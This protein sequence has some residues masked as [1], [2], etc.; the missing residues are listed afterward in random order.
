[1]EPLTALLWIAAISS[2]TAGGP[3]FD[4]DPRID[5]P[6][7]AAAGAIAFGWSLSD[8]LGGPRCAP[9]CRIEDVAVLDRWV[10]GQYD[11]TWRTVSDISSA[12]VLLGSAAVLF[13]DEAPLDALQDAV[14]VAQSV[15][16]ANAIGVAIELAAR[17]PRPL[18]YSARVPAEERFSG[19]SALSFPS[20]HTAGAFAATLAMYSA[21]ERLHPD[22]AIP[23]VVLGVGLGAASFLGV[24]RV[25]AGDHFP[26][27]VIM[28]AVI[29]AAA[30]LV[31]PALHDAPV[32]LTGGAGL[33]S[34]TVGLAFSW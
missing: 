12:A 33:D 26:T 27:D 31:V 5:L 34:S 3:A 8:E 18:V 10:A 24:S 21:M 7:I 22:T 13:I 9:D 29:G 28:G 14:V 15:L 6:I 23:Y 1:M 32:R 25:A 20:G 17:R 19:H 16:I 11:P 4:V 30:G 2:T